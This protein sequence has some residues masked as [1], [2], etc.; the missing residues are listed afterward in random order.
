[1]GLELLS[2]KSDQWGVE[3]PCLGRLVR[4][5]GALCRMKGFCDSIQVE[6]PVSDFLKKMCG[7]DGLG[8]APCGYQATE[9]AMAERSGCIVSRTMIRKE[10]GKNL[11]RA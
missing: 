5:G 3:G 11:K 4:D 6:A 2:D 1:M 9:F 7:K 10:P 8:D